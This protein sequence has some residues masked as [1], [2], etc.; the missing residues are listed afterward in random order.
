MDTAR[1]RFLEK[2]VKAIIAGIKGDVRLA[3]TLSGG[4]HLIR[5]V[6]LDSLQLIRF[7]LQ[8]E[9]ELGVEFDFRSFDYDHM[10]SISAF[11]QFVAQQ[12]RV[13]RIRS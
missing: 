4:A 8:V 6:E 5:D 10:R 2:K 11:C 9:E 13:G 12:E 1:V 7:I 3:D